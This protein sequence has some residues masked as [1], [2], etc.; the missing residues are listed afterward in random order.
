[1]ERPGAGKRPSPRARGTG[2]AQPGAEMWPGAY[3]PAGEVLTPAEEGV[4]AP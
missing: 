1:M 4:N 3:W 2:A